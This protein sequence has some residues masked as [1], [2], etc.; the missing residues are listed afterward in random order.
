MAFGQ[1]IDVN[2]TQAN[3][4][5]VVAAPAPQAVMN[6][7][8]TITKEMAQKQGQEVHVS[9]PLRAL[10]LAD[11]NHLE[12]CLSIKKAALAAVEHIAKT[13]SHKNDSQPAPVAEKPPV[14]I[15]PA[16]KVKLNKTR[17]DGS[18][19]IKIKPT[20]IDKK[21]IKLRPWAPVIQKQTFN[22]TVPDNITETSK[23]NGTIPIT[24]EAVNPN[25]TLNLSCNSYDDPEMVA[26]CNKASQEAN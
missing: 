20:V 7:P 13:H 21:V 25:N 3:L 15:V 12:A 2:V 10:A 1:V 23:V 14:T 16:A 19:I 26:E 5:P 18:E 22:V 9:V 6:I 17:S 4:T 8:L 11:C 24:V